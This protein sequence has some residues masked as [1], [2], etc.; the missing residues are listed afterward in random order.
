MPAKFGRNDKCPCGSGKKYKNCCLRTQD[1]APTPLPRLAPAPP[2][3]PAPVACEDD[4]DVL[5]NRV[6]DLIQE[7]RLEDAED[8]IRL[9]EAEFPDMIDVLERTAQLR[10]AQGRRTEARQWYLKAGQYAQTHDGFEPEGIA[11]YFDKARRLENV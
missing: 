10:E 6:V 7:G 5:S 9:L 11:W 4:L 3:Q 8:A 1:S 2:P